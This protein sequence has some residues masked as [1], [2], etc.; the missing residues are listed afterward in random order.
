MKQNEDSDHAPRL[1]SLIALA[2]EI[3]SIL[4]KSKSRDASCVLMVL[5]IAYYKREHL[6]KQLFLDRMSNG[7]DACDV[8]IETEKE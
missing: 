3:K 7:W 6:S 2:K 4:D 8:S 1:L 5:L